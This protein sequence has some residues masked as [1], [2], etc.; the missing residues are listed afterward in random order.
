M[1]TGVSEGDTIPA[2]FDSMIAKIIAY[3]RDR[4]EAL[5]R[6]RRA[7]AETTVIIDGGATN[8][9]FVLDLLDQPEVIDAQRGHRLD[10]PGPRPRAGWCRTG[11]PA[12]RWPRPPSRPTRTRR[13]WPGSGCCP[14]RS[15]AGR[16]CST[17]PAGRWSS[18]CAA[19]GTGC[20]SARVGAHRFRVAIDA[21]NGT[22]HTADVELDRFDAHT[23]QI[24]VNGQRFRL[25]TGTH[26]PIHL[27]EVDGVA[28]RISRDEGGVVRSPAPAL[29]V[30]TPLAVGAEVEAGAP[31][32]VL[33]SMKMETVLRA[34]FRA[35]LKECLVSVGSQVETGAPLLRLEPLGDGDA[36]SR[37]AGRRR[38]RARPARRARRVPAAERVTRG[39]RGPAQPAARLRRRPARRG[40][41]C[42]TA[43]SPR[44]PRPAAAATGRWRGR[45]SCSRCSPTWPS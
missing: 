7:L 43:T 18:S 21:G 25:V 27:V 40:A 20:R 9:S 22:P 30:A 26:G 34:P 6:L 15:A 36:A 24:V 28:H 1:D 5:G 14:P 16:R 35:R 11:T 33:E 23:G 41:G 12:S 4:D 32:L 2:D 3:G 42:S 31:V 19:P 44:G 38:R 13:T 45:S 39:L 17:T 8:K 37:R 10:R 29:V